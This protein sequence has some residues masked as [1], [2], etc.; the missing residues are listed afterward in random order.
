ME[1]M[2]TNYVWTNIQ[3]EYL[4]NKMKTILKWARKLQKL[5]QSSNYYKHKNQQIK[6]NRLELTKGQCWEHIYR[7]VLA[8]W[9]QNS[10]RFS[11]MNYWALEIPDTRHGLFP[12]LFDFF[13]WLRVLIRCSECRIGLFEPCFRSCIKKNNVKRE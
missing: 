10:A 13:Y 12:A 11:H 4:L 2:K 5:L 6:I 1:L 7:Q 3:Q 9:K 8:T